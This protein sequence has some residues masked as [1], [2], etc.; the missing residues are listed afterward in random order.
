[1]ETEIQKLN[2][3]ITELENQVKLISSASTIPYSVEQAFKQRLNTTLLDQ[4]P[5]GLANAPLP[6][7]TNPSG[8]ATVDSQARTA[9][10]D[11]NTVLASLGLT[12]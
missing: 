11:I 4:I 10:V 3:R 7:V 6:A 2:R 1:M 8:G 5:A 9:I 12:I